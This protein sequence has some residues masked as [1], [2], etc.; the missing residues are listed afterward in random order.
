[1]QR[2]GMLRQKE[3][4]NINN[5]CRLGFVCDV[6]VSL[7][8]GEIEAI[9]VPGKMKFIN[10]NKKDELVIEWCRVKV[11]GDVILVDLPCECN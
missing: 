8:K 9:I 1:M 4:I 2:A 10:F 5:G 3:V 7:C 6:E 11:I